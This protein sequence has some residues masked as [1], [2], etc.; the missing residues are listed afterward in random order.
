MLRYCHPVCVE[1]KET[2]LNF[3]NCR[4]GQFLMSCN[5]EQWLCQEM[6]NS[7][8]QFDNHRFQSHSVTW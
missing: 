8:V 3:K 5:Y 2:V 6:L 4:L 1:I 7:E